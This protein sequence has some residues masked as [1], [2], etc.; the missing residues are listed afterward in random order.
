[1]RDKPQIV[2]HYGAKVYFVAPKAANVRHTGKV[3]FCYEGGIP[4]GNTLDIYFDRRRM[5]GPNDWYPSKRFTPPHRDGMNVC[6]ADGHVRRIDVSDMPKP[7]TVAAIRPPW[8]YTWEAKKIS[9]LLD[10]SP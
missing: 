9:H 8:P 2:V 6:F 1:M 5:Y 3:V 7:G 10:Y 4:L